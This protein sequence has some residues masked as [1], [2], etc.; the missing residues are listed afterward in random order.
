MAIF[1]GRIRYDLDFAYKR[2]E[3]GQGRQGLCRAGAGLFG[4]FLS[5]RGPCP[6]ARRYQ[7][8]DRA[9]RHGSVAGAGRGHARAGAVPFLGA[10]ADGSWGSGGDAIHPST[11]RSRT[12][13]AQPMAS[14]TASE[15]HMAPKICGT[16]PGSRLRPLFAERQI[17]AQWSQALLDSCSRNSRCVARV[18][19]FAGTTPGLNRACATRSCG[20]GG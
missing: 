1:D 20:A 15:Q 9:S 14:K 10:D 6:R 19:D 16:W 12:E 11:P 13:S 7:I 17:L 5:G 8:H 3:E 18:N 2:M 4:L